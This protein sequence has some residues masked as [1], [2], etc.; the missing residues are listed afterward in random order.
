MVPAKALEQIKQLA[1]ELGIDEF[2]IFHGWRTQAELR[3]IIAVSSIGVVPHRVTAHTN[4]TLPNKIYD[5][6]ALAKPVIVSSARA[7]EDVVARQDAG[8]SFQDGDPDSLLSCLRK[9][10]SAELRQQMGE[11]GR[12]H[13]RERLN[14]SRDEAVLLDAVA[15]FSARSDPVTG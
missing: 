11:S 3:S 12:R 5:Y 2:V 1:A 15:R 9:L 14:W 4:T 13:V 8:W 6:M 7:L 10:Q